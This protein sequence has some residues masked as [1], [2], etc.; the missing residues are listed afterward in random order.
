[1]IKKLLLIVNP[2]SGKMRIKSQLMGICK[3]FCDADF[4]VNVHITRCCM[5][6]TRHVEMYGKEYD[7]IVACGGDGTLNE[8]VNGALK[9]GYE[10][11]V[12]FLPCGT[13]NDLASTFSIPKDLNRASLLITY[14][15]SKLVD[16]GEFNHT[17]NFSY[18][19][20]FGAFSEVAYSTDQKL[21]NLFGHVAYVSE[22]ISRLRDLRPY[23]M[24]V[25]CDG[26]EVE[27]EF[28]FGAVANALSLGGV[29]KLKRD[30]V[31]LC[32]GFHE[33]LLIR[34]PKNSADLA[35]LSKEFL[36]G[37]YENKS[38]LFFKGQKITFECDESLPWC[39]DG[40]YAGNHSRVHIR[41]LHNRLRIICP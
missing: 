25:N 7:V 28:L 34:N 18:V 16:F 9:I 39:L 23:C 3:V 11:E 13:T 38:I 35:N 8:V 1:M 40:E 30:Q 27:G 24:K 37:N 21:K 12:G 20:S 29:M 26:K 22:A 14:K 10:G 6:A 17:R 41:N 15:K 32:D 5:D 33:V 4:S 19:A 31:D 36:S 2:T